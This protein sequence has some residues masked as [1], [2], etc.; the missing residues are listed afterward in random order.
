[1]TCGSWDF[2]PAGQHYFCHEASSK[3]FLCCVKSGSLR[4][5]IICID[6]ICSKSG[7]TKKKQPPKQSDLN[8]AMFNTSKYFPHS[9]WHYQNQST[10]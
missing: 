5:I 1:M 2:N 10:L 8:I 6:L 4:I 7:E 9:I 3:P